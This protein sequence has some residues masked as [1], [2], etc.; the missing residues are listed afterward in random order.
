VNKI[1]SNWTGL[2]KKL[3]AGNQERIYIK[4]KRTYVTSYFIQE[5]RIEDVP[6]W[7]L[8]KDTSGPVI[9]DPKIEEIFISIEKQEKKTLDDL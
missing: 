8:I 5:M 2:G 6:F 3:K 9:N 1:Y 7:D 4:G